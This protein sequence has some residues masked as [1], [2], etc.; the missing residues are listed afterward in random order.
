MITENFMDF[1]LL[2]K[3]WEI[4]RHTQLSQD[5]FLMHI[6]ILV[7]QV[8]VCGHF[9]VKIQGNT[10]LGHMIDSRVK[11]GVDNRRICCK[12]QEEIEPHVAVTNCIW[13]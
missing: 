8:I 2:K 11:G 10:F 6:S 1:L 13:T 9:M 7:F 3:S 4:E 12:W 5:L